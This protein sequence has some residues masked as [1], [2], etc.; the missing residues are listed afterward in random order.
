VL[1]KGGLS[2]A[3][4]RAIFSHTAALATPTAVWRG[5]VRQAG[6]LAVDSLDALIDTARALA[7]GKA[8]TGTRA[9]LVAMTGGPSVAMTDAFST[10]GLDVPLLDDASYGKLG[11]FFQIVGGSFRNPLDAGSTIVMGFRA[12]NLERILSVLDTAPGIDVVALDLGAGLTLD[13]WHEH[14]DLAATVLAVLASFARQS[15]KPFAVVV[16]APHRPAEAA[17]LRAQLHARGVLPFA[18]APRAAHALRQLIE[19]SRFRANLA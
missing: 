10:A 9:G 19:Y 16:D 4:Q 6:A 17:A 11:E 14:P 1:W 12:D 2:D 3:G 7:A 13:R 5:M 8:A 18:S 15:A